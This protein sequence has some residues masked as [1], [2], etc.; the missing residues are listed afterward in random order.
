MPI[1]TKTLRILR[2]AIF[3][4][5]ILVLGVQAPSAAA[6][7]YWQATFGFVKIWRS[8]LWSNPTDA[9]MHLCEI[10][11][12]P[13]CP[14]PNACANYFP[15][16]C[17]PGWYFNEA[18]H[19]CLPIKYHVSGADSEPTCEKDGSNPCDVITGRKTQREV[20]FSMGELTFVR[21]YDS[22]AADPGAVTM[23][24]NWRHNFEPRMDRLPL[25]RS[26][27]TPSF[28]ALL[29]IAAHFMRSNEYTS[30]QDACEQGWDDI[31]NDYRR[32][33][34]VNAVASLNGDLCELTEQ[35]VRV[36]V[37]PVGSSER[38]RARS[39]VAGE[40]GTLTSP[41]H[42]MTTS[43]GRHYTFEEVSPGVYEDAN[44]YPVRLEL[45]SANSQWLFHD[46]NNVVD[47]I[48]DGKLI[49]RTFPNGRSLYLTY[50]ATSGLLTTVTNDDGDSLQ[51]A[52]NPRGQLDSITHP[53]GQISYGYGPAY[54]YNTLNNLVTVTYEDNSVREYHYED[55]NLKNHL[56]GITDERG[57]RYAT[58]AYDTDG[59]AVSSTH[60]NGANLVTYT[61]NATSTTVTDPAGGSR[62]YN[63]GNAGRRPVITSISGDKCVDCP[64]NLMKTRTYDANGFLDEVTD[65]EGNI[66]DYDHDGRGLETQ[67]IEAKGTADERTVVTQWHPDLRLPTKIIESGRTTD[68][69]YDSAGRVLMRKVTP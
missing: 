3:T 44:G 19:D 37:L 57:V 65:W 32:G 18:A 35:G 26:D 56:T 48:D 60:A 61:H 52:Y 23:G 2:E 22:G 46:R 63:I 20:D 51:F 14:D 54:G 16:N 6:A 34:L 43:S 28:P 59:R 47:R 17:G 31:K 36:G 13:S 53:A 49:E 33:S 10:R 1:H 42:T 7:D 40:W 69:T 55:P 11:G 8:D 66:T 68:I 62:V 15:G 30:R 50:D 25:L 4:I 64:R 39:T 29:P 45:D 27:G 9:C 24:A 21:T 67:R 12:A 38:S 41:I 58:W 5:I